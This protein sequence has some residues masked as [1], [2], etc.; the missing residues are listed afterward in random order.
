MWESGNEKEIIQ[1]FIFSLEIQQEACHSASHLPFP[2]QSNARVVT[3]HCKVNER[4]SGK[5]ERLRG[6]R[7][8][9]VGGR[10]GNA[11]GASL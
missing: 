8:G 6:A 11:E 5:G 3:Q 1:G 7:K 2:M 4:G 10:S 9:G